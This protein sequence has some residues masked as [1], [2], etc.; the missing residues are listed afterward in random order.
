MK[1][2]ELLQILSKQEQK[3][4]ELELKGKKKNQLEKTYTAIKKAAKKGVEP[5]KEQLYKAVFSEKFTTKKDYR[6][7]HELRVLNEFVED[8]LVRQQFL[9][10]YKQEEYKSDLRLLVYY[11][12]KKAYDLYEKQWNKTYKRSS[13][14]DRF[15][16]MRA[17]LEMNFSVWYARVREDSIRML[18][19]MR[20]ST[21]EMVSCAENAAIEE[22]LK[23]QQLAA[24]TEAI[25]KQIQPKRVLTLPK[26]PLVST[27]EVEELP[28]VSQFLHHIIG[29]YTKAG[30]EKI[31][32]IKK[33]L[34]L[35][36]AV[37]KLRPNRYQLN[38]KVTLLGH[39]AIEHSIYNDNVAAAE[40]YET[41]L[42]LALDGNVQNLPVILH[43]F[44]MNSLH[45]KNYEK[46]IGL[47]ENHSEVI[48]SMPQIKR[49]TIFSRCWAYLFLG[50][51]GQALD[52]LNTL[53]LSKF[54]EKDYY[55][56]RMLY[57]A[58]YCETDDWESAERELTNTYQA[59][60]Y[61]ELQ[62]PVFK[63]QLDCYKWLLKIMME[64]SKTQRKEEIEGLKK[65]MQ[66]IV[67]GNPSAYSM[68]LKW[69]D[70]YLEKLG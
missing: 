24:F 54:G 46:V 6:L 39:L 66:K 10:K 5:E 62:N 14:H 51:G 41:L 3:L 16:E 68:L 43:N 45:L 70:S 58:L 15:S 60:H 42:P 21:D 44:M 22:F 52:L 23:T 26:V 37:D 4:L 48:D 29:Q 7:R 31:E 47:Y 40:V 35:A 9:K 59:M 57:I 64:P 12:E 1:S 63:T 49:V 25:F 2:I 65:H 67:K 36:D 19:K 53:Q 30:V 27:K 33:A 56:A 13:A 32:H 8:F 50:K 55:Y 20:K 11:R 38:T 34:E 69:V 18:D 17:L 28:V 61:K